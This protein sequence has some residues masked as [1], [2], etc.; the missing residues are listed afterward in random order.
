LFQAWGRPS[1]GKKNMKRLLIGAILGLG[2]VCVLHAQDAAPSGMDVRTSAAPDFANTSAVRVS[3]VS[4][5]FSSTP[6]FATDAG[7]EASISAASA[8]LPTAVAITEAD[9]ASPEPQPKFLYGGRDDYRWQLGLGIAWERFR[10][11]IYNASAIGVNSSVA[12]FT[13]DWFGIEGD[14]TSTFAPTIYQNEHVKLLN[15]VGGPKIAWRQRRWEPWAH[16]LVGG[17]H[18]FPQTAGNSKTG[19]AVQAG[20]GADFRWNP[21]FSFRFDADYLRTMLFKSSQNNFLLGGGIV[22]HF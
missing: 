1:E 22:F 20:G 7:L 9:P 12:Y 18:A 10:S 6:F 4:P 14:I 21:R 11:S 19:F 5:T 15:F 16:V 17:T 2:S 3:I 13:N 8:P